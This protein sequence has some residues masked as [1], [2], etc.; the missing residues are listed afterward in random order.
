MKI[1][2]GSQSSARQ[3]LLKK[4]GV[5]FSIMIADIDEKSVRAENPQELPLFIARQKALELE[6]KINGKAILITA[7]TIILFKGEVREKPQSVSQVREWLESYSNAP[8]I[9]YTAVVVV[10]TSTKRKLE[11][12]RSAE[13][14]FK[15]FTREV[16]DQ[17]IENGFVFNVAGGFKQEHPLMR[18]FIDNIKG[19]EDVIIGLPVELTKRLIKN[20]S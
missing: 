18:P 8:A 12:V 7:D 20:V 2:L 14:L 10:N 11:A 4:A 3:E 17:S 9:A 15:P 19:S 5:E 6:K 13:I 16:I 1:I